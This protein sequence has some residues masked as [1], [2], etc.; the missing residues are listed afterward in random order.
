MRSPIPII[1]LIIAMVL[2][3]AIPLYA[4][5]PIPPIEWEE[6]PDSTTHIY[7]GWPADSV[8]KGYFDSLWANVLTIPSGGLS[9][10]E[11]THISGTFNNIVGWTSSELCSWS[12]GCST[13]FVSGI[14]DIS[15]IAN[16]TWDVMDTLFLRVFCKDANDTLQVFLG[17][18]AFEDT[19]C[20]WTA[21]SDTTEHV[22]GGAS[23]TI[24]V[25]PNI[26]AVPEDSVTAIVLLGDAQDAPSDV[27]VYSFKQKLRRTGP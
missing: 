25:V 5:D 20:T 6:L 14:Y 4:V 16:E 10:P 21:I 7:V 2:Q 23:T 22:G 8:D 13:R 18:K 1:I 9:L 12:P 27:L 15:H 26:S 11:T 17:R 3:Y 19:V 24:T